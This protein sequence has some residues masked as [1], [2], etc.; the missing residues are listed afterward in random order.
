MFLQGIR[1]IE[2]QVNH[3]PAAMGA[4]KQTNMKQK[5][6]G[7]KK[8][9]ARADEPSES[10]ELGRDLMETI[11]ANDRYYW[12]AYRLRTPH[13]H[14]YIAMRTRSNVV[15]QR[16]A[17]CPALPT[18]NIK[19][20][21]LSVAVNTPDSDR[22]ISLRSEEGVDMEKP[23]E[24]VLFSIRARSAVSQMVTEAEC[25]RYHVGIPAFHTVF[26]I[27]IVPVRDWFPS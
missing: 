10:Q 8:L 2:C 23:P 1:L 11:S 6:R 5:A 9:Y 19:S 7:K 16:R 27:S 4:R 24:F 12:Y 21:Y 22:T 15:G 26:E 14:R 25:A 18:L 20:V 17:S 13:T 3:E